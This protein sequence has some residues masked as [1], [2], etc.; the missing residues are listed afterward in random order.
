MF[1]LEDAIAQWRQQMLNA[2]LKS[3]VP[4]DELEIHLRD[5]IAAQARSGLEMQ[6]AFE[7]AVERVGQ[8]S[9]LKAEF[10]KAGDAKKARELKLMG[11]IL[12]GTACFYALFVGVFVLFKVGSFS[13]ISFQ[14]QMSAS[15]A[16]ALTA[17][18]MVSG[19]LAHRFLPV[20]SH[21]RT[22]VGVYAAGLFPL[23][24]WL[25]VFYQLVMTRFEF[26]LSQLVVAM[27]W[28]LTPWGAILGC[29]YGL[30]RAALQKA[31]RSHS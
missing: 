27:L 2:G 8:A 5:D 10:E 7:A 20:I 28:A 22:R 3:P 19:H 23:F 12:V 24:G 1:N 13:D 14:E 9:A 26:N 15:V 6:Q 29:I 18:L 11:A 25:G 4:L 31:A 17:L 30:E 21:K 16:G